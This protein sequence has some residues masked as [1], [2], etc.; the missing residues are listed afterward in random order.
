MQLIRY[1]SLAVALVACRASAGLVMLPRARADLGPAGPDH[2]FRLNPPRYRSA[3]Y[4][5]AD[6]V[7][8]ATDPEGLIAVGAAPQED[9]NSD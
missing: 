7:D 3:E 8:P 4:D 6:M 9:R 5:G 1:D 2:L